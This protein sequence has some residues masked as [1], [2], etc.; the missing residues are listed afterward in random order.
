LDKRTP[1]AAAIAAGLIASASASA[2]FAHH[3]YAMFDRDKS[4]T[5]SGTILQWEMVNP[6][7]FLWVVVKPDKGP[8]VT[9]GLESGGIA[10]LQRSGITKSMV[11]PGDKVTVM[12]HPLKD[13]RNGGQLVN[14]TLSDG[15][16]LRPNGGGQG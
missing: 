13:G 12:I 9:Y 6:H 15:R 3:S 4:V 7:S 5:M 14:L 8:E 10:A 11:K 16:Q 2:A 1:L